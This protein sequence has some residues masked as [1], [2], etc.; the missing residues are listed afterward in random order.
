MRIR[1][2]IWVSA[3]I[4]RAQAGGAFVAVLHKG[5]EEAGTIFLL[6]DDRSGKLCL[7]GPAPQMMYEPDGDTDRQFECLIDAGTPDEIFD[8]IKSERSFDPDVWVIEIDDRQGRN[9][10]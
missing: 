5:N 4:R 10:V 8:R 6:V 9:F 3:L 1:S 7:Y 2:A